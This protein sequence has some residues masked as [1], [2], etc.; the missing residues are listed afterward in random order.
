MKQKGQG[1]VEFAIIVPILVALGVAV[2]YVGI[3]FLDYTQYSNAA[4]DA[5]RDISVQSEVIN[6]DETYTTAA[7]FRQN[8][9]NAINIGSGATYENV[10]SR[11]EHPFTTIYQSKWEAQFYYL[12]AST[13]TLQKT[14]DATKADTIEV[15]ITLRLKDDTEP[16]SY[17]ADWLTN[18]FEL[19]AIHYK[20]VLE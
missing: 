8:I 17:L 2:I 5:A 4:R 16:Q 15:S 14:N 11:Y 20:M 18:L 12:D 7:T 13:G 6:A 10:V 19:P 9:V 1:I 3:M